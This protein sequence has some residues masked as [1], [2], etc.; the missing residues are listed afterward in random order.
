MESSLSEVLASLEKA[1]EIKKTSA[2]S[3]DEACEDKCKPHKHQ[4]PEYNYG[5]ID[6]NQTSISY[7]Y[8][9]ID[10]E[11]YVVL[12]DIA[13]DE[14]N[15]FKYGQIHWDIYYTHPSFPYRGYS[16]GPYIMAS[17]EYAN[18]LHYQLTGHMAYESLLNKKYKPTL[19]SIW[20]LWQG[21]DIQDE[22]VQFERRYRGRCYIHAKDMRELNHGN[23]FIEPCGMLNLASDVLDGEKQ[24]VQFIDHD[25]FTPQSNIIF[26]HHDLYL[27]LLYLK[28]PTWKEEIMR[29]LY[30]QPIPTEVP[31]DLHYM[32]IV[33]DYE[34][35][36]E[37][38]KKEIEA[39]KKEHE[40]EL[41]SLMK[42]IERLECD[43]DHAQGRAIAYR[44]LYKLNV[45][46]GFKF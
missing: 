23:K 31:Y 22:I 16:L 32:K 46:D 42:K 12:D 13:K 33:D 27:Y 8:I 20:E 44:R 18:A 7:R 21:Y 4:E 36:Q 1:I 41:K 24:Y 6:I 34:R 25:L 9:T 40:E 43:L 3:T 45:D 35:M 15:E 5:Q 38:H 28:H 10:E 26:I 14:S 11:E 19:H 30:H 37:E 29:Y 39:L 17:I 2:H